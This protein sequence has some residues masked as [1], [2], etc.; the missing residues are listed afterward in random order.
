MGDSDDNFVI[1]PKLIFV[2]KS[3][4]NKAIDLPTEAP[5][6]DVPTFSLTTELEPEE[7]S[8]AA[9]WAV[10]LPPEEETEVSEQCL[11]DHIKREV[12]RYL[13]MNGPI[14]KERHAEVPQEPAKK[15]P[16]IDSLEALI[17]SKKR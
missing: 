1:P 3:Q 4:R 2:P 6:S 17:A 8:C 12:T 11:D 16:R 14:L 13:E 9:Y 5:T 15:E 7:I 10:P